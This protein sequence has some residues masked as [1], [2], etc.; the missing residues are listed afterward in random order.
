MDN[1]NLPVINLHEFVDWVEA[2]PSNR[3]FKVDFNGWEYGR[4]LSV[5]VYNS[6]LKESQYVTRVDEINLE[7]RAK[8]K[9]MKQFEALKAEFEGV[10]NG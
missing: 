2:D 6:K 4:R 5:W 8:E 1:N 3:S 10:N 9:K 7:E